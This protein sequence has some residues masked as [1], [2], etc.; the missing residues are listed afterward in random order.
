M[1]EEFKMVLTAN[2]N[3]IEYTRLEYH[4]FAVIKKTQ[5]KSEYVTNKKM[6][7]YNGQS[8]IVF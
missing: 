8:F 3:L 4:E 5:N 1:Y 7:A 2:L 6:W